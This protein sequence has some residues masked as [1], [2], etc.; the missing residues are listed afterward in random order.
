[1]NTGT[2]KKF[3]TNYTDLK[4][5]LT[6]LTPS[7]LQNIEDKAKILSLP[8]CIIWLGMELAELSTIEVAYATKAHARG[9]LDAIHKAAK[10]LFQNMNTRNGALAALEYLK[11]TSGTFKVDATQI[12]S[13][14][15]GGFNFSVT[16]TPE[17]TPKDTQGKQGDSEIRGPDT[18]GTLN[19]TKPALAEVSNS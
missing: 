5:S 18:N 19:S 3:S 9:A 15:G 2:D 14:Q 11:H 16:L 4:D 6:I 7:D 17:E 10:H 13:S 1:M 12:P 8:D